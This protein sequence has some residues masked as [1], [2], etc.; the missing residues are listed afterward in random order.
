[1]LAW[2]THYTEYASHSVAPH[3][4][5]I[6]FN[7]ATGRNGHRRCAV[8]FTASSTPKRWSTYTTVGGAAVGES[9]TCGSS[10]IEILTRQPEAVG[11]SCTSCS[12]EGGVA[13]NPRVY[14]SP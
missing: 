1:M 5:F 4:A 3:M 14:K 2:R 10:C 9:S 6:W 13:A 12:P 7:V 8:A 11:A